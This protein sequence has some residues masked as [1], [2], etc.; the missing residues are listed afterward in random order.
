MK[1]RGQNTLYE[2]D[3]KQCESFE[4]LFCSTTCL[5]RNTAC[6]HHHKTSTNTTWNIISSNWWFHN[7]NFYRKKQSIYNETLFS[8]G[9]RKNNIPQNFGNEAAEVWSKNM[10]IE[11]IAKK[12]DCYGTF[13]NLLWQWFSSKRQATAYFCQYFNKYLSETKTC[14]KTK[15]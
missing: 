7:S 14:E 4:W 1:M 6:F 10:W 12:R 3:M 5:V 11:K 8:I 13:E 15:K 9:N 2:F